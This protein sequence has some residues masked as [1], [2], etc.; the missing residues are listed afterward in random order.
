MEKIVKGLEIT[1]SKMILDERFQNDVE[2]SDLALANI[3]AL[4][5]FDYNGKL[6]RNFQTDTSILKFAISEDEK[7][8]F[9]VSYEPDI[10]IVKFNISDLL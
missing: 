1:H 5:G 6:I 2:M 9:A 10:D 3:E 7:T 4:A 8:I